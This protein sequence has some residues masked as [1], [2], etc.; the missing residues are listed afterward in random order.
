M[1]ALV[2]AGVTATCSGADKPRYGHLDVDSNLPDAGSRW[3]GPAATPSPKPC[4]P[5]ADPVYTAELD[6]QLAETG[7]ARVWVP[8]ATPLAAV[9]VPGADLRAVAGAAG[10]GD[11]RPR[12]ETACGAAIASVADDLADAEI[13]VTPAGPVGGGALRSAHRRAAQPRGAQLRR[14]H[15][16]H[17]AHRADAV[18]H[19]LAVRRL[20]R[21]TAP[22]RARRLELPT[23]ALD[24]RFRLRAGLRRRRLAARRDPGPQ[25]AVL[26][27]AARGRR[28]AREAGKPAPVGSLLQVDPADSVHL[29]ALKA[30]GN[31]LAA[32]QRPAGRPGAV[33][34]RLVETTGAATRVAVG[35]PA[36]HRCAT[37]QL[38]D[39]LETPL[40]RK[41]SLDAARP[42]GRPPCWPGS[43]CP[44]AA[45]AASAPSWPRRPRPPSRCTRG[46]GCTTAAPRH[47]AGC[48]PSPTC[49]PQLVTAEPGGEVSLRLTAASDCT[50]AALHGTVAM[51]CPDGWSARPAELPFTLRSRRAPGGRRGAVDARPHASPGLYPVRAQLRRDRG[52][53]PGRLATGGRGRVRG[54]GRRVRTTGERWSTLSTGRPTSTLAAGETAG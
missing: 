35:S 25:R 2:R 42:P 24:T 53:S 41:R 4:W 20:D 28:R 22:H 11:R 19:R 9:W 23:A 14:R 44:R 33:A 1:V 38:A 6:R 7:R 29:G 12:R 10:A 13:V 31:P 17:P 50:D 52:R 15:R 18:L 51:V 27:P 5:Q 26:P 36:G 16:R 37:L 49:T 46:T 43:T 8:A 45:D 30:A 21:R 48:P 3:A 34:L 39:L 47:W 40:G 54:G 32:R